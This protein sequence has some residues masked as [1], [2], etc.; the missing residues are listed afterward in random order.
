MIDPAARVGEA[1]HAASGT[2]LRE[3]RVSRDPRVL[4]G[5]D[6]DLRAE[7]DVA[8]LQHQPLDDVRDLLDRQEPLA[9]R[10]GGMA[11]DIGVSTIPGHTAHALIPSAWFSSCS[12]SVST[13]RGILADGVLAYAGMHEHPASLQM[14]TIIPRRR[15]RVLGRTRAHKHRRTAE[16]DIERDVPVVDV[17]LVQRLTVRNARGVDQNI[18]RTQLAFHA[19]HQAVQLRIVGDIGAH[20]HSRSARGGDPGRDPL[21]LGASPCRQRDAHQGLPDARSA[22]LDR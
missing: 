15:A 1:P 17:E 6:Q 3:C 10:V 9:N 5:P 2:L 11:P 16:V 20:A 7:L 21:E 12:S 14:L 13:R 8:A 4:H 19:I 18:D 22:H